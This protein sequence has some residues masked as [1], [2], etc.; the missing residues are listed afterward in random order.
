MTEPVDFPFAI[1]ALETPTGLDFEAGGAAAV[2]LV[3]TVATVKGAEITAGAAVMFLAADVVEVVTF[4]AVAAA[5][6]V[7]VVLA[8]DSMVE[9]VTAETVTAIAGAA[10]VSRTTPDDATDAPLAPWLKF[11]A[12][13]LKSAALA[14]PS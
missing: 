5:A 12:S 3:V 1:T 11:A 14:R 9:V 10:G 6:G 8:V 13:S 4:G 2:D 7:A